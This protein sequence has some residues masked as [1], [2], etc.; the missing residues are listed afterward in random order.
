VNIKFEM[1][2]AFLLRAPD[3]HSVVV[4]MRDTLAVLHAELETPFTPQ[5]LVNAQG[6]HA[7]APVAVD[8]EL[9]PYDMGRTRFTQCRMSIDLPEV[10][11]NRID[12]TKRRQKTK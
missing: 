12:Y 3:K 2:N 11:H 1:K 5:Q 7:M 10:Q 9:G 6:V 4:L 8:M